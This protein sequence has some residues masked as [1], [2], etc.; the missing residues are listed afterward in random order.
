MTSTM[1]WSS[2]THRFGD[3]GAQGFPVSAVE[4]RYVEALDEY[5]W[6]KDDVAG[7]CDHYSLRSPGRRACTPGL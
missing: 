4:S 6:D 5:E 2:S 7:C 1:S 3:A